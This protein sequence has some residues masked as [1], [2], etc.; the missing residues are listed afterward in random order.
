[1]RVIQ[2]SPAAGIE[3]GSPAI[4]AE[5]KPLGQPHDIFMDCYYRIYSKPSDSKL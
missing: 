5:L 1:M 2:K 4:L 3:P